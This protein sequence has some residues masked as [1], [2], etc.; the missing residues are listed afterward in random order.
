MKDQESK[1]RRTESSEYPDRYTYEEATK[2]STNTFVD[3]VI[4]RRT[5]LS[6]AAAT[7]AA[8]ALPSVVSADVSHENMTDEA[9]FAVN[10]TPEEYEAHL[11]FSFVNTEAVA[12]FEEEYSDPDWDIEAD[13]SPPKGVV[14]EG[15]TPAGHAYLT[16]DELESLLDEV[17]DP[18]SIDLIEHSIGAN[19]FW[20]LDDWPEEDT[21][22]DRVFPDIEAA[23]DYTNNAE[24][25]AGLSYLEDQYPDRINVREVGQ[26]PGWENVL[27]GEETDPK[28]V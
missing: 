9:E 19:P 6:I 26:S 12:V 27:T 3:E 28:D 10:A 11:V 25:Y 21:Y 4:N 20:K 24:S 17:V 15:P 14:R 8:L 22:S 1:D 5:F 18:D 16:A 13:A 23:R 7:G 2:L